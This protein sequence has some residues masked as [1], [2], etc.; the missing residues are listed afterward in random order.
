MTYF[1][2]ALTNN[3]ARLIVS[4]TQTTDKAIADMVA[5]HLK[6]QGHIVVRREET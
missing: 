1:V 3:E 2:T 6:V 5:A 4:E